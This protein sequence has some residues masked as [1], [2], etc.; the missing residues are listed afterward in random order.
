MELSYRKTKVRL[1]KRERGRRE[2]LLWIT[3]VIKT[4]LVLKGIYA[5][6]V[7]TDDY[8]GSDQLCAPSSTCL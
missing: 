1:Q 2:D 7:C 4:Y 8:A 3:E 5:F 6:L